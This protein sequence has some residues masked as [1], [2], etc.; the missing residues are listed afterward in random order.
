M[1]N[2]V[3]PLSIEA[4]KYIL[5]SAQQKHAEFSEPI[6]NMGADNEEKVKACLANPFHTFNGKFLYNSFLD[7]ATIL[8]YSLIK[9]H[10]LI[11]GNKRMA[12]LATSFFFMLNGRILL[13]RSDEE[14]YQFARLI[15][16]S[17]NEEWAK[18]TIFKTL[19]DNSLRF[20]RLKRAS[21]LKRKRRLRKR[22]LFCPLYRAIYLCKFGVLP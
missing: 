14:L 13:F 20:E 5:K 19:V 10:A 3:E 7:K 8:F 18:R 11:N 21:I 17:Q 9:S 4:F 15:A 16:Q 22:V 12:I 6:P 2:K 1:N